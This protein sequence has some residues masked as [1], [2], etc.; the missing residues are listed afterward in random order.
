MIFLTKEL[1][2]PV[3]KISVTCFAGDEDCPR[4]ELTASCW[5]KAG[6]PRERIFF[7]GKRRQL[8]DCW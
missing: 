6:I 5:E 7:F 8:V 2:I 3:E 4:D 1:G